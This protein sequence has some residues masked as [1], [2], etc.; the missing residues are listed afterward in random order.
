MAPT[1]Q[2]TSDKSATEGIF[3]LIDFLILVPRIANV[4]L[5]TDYS[6]GFEVS[7]HGLSIAT[8]VCRCYCH[9][10]PKLRYRIAMFH[11]DWS[12]CAEFAQ[13]PLGR[14]RCT[15]E[16]HDRDQNEGGGG[17]EELVN[18]TYLVEFFFDPE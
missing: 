2:A 13:V 6:K 7:T 8:Y 16:N 15:H 18:F 5:G 9:T 3:I 12:S 1:T 11:R 14:W 17:H 10:N 4:L